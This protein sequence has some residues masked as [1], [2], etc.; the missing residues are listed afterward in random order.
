MTKERAAI[1]AAVGAAILFGAAAPAAKLLVTA[2]PG[3]G[4]APAFALP[5]LV[6]GLLYLGSGAGLGVV[7]AV[8]RPR[9]PIPRAGRLRFAVAVAVGGM[10]GPALLMIGLAT[11]AASTASLLLN[12]ESVLTAL[13]AWTVAREHT[14]PRIVAGFVAIAAGGVVLSLDGAA[15]SLST[16]A[17]FVVAACACWA[18]DNNLT[19]AVSSA[20][21]VL[22]ATIKGLAAGATNTAL[23]FVVGH[24]A[25]PSSSTLLGALVV[26]FFGYGASL[27][28][29]VVALSKL[30]TA[31]TSAYFSLAPFVG[32]ALSVAL[33]HDTVTTSFVVAGGLMLVGLLLHVTERHGHQHV[34]EELVHSH[35]H[36]HDEHHQHAHEHKD[37]VVVDVSKPHSHEHRH[38]PLAHAHAHAP[39][40]HHRHEH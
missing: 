23:A 21:P 7:L 30:G 18:V 40:L 15:L 39:D 20:D 31:R 29:F 35:E 36:R 24:A 26:G 5:F 37:G 8:R 16:G 27:V 17:L 32:A 1:P 28:L 33:L 25:L 13:I 10:A 19:Q 12:L 3:S 38:E 14:Q 9:A 11:T 4:S 22:L 34:H 6:A 2:G